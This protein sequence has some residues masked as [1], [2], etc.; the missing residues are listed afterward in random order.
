M[1]F[2]IV[3]LVIWLVNV[4][5]INMW[6]CIFKLKVIFIYK[7]FMVIVQKIVYGVQFYI[8]SGLM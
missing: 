3:V 4:T 2:Y 1:W 5:E 8:V 6:F 7:M